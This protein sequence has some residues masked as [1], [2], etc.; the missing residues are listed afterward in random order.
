M[1]MNFVP[2]IDGTDGINTIQVTIKQLIIYT[3]P[4]CQWVFLVFLSHNRIIQCGGYVFFCFYF[5]EPI[6]M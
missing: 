3:C 1:C 6:L 5:Y 4:N 2:W